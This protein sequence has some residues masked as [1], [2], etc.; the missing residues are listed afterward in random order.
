MAVRDAPAP[1]Q[2]APTASDPQAME[3]EPAQIWEPGDC[4]DP[5]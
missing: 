3:D 5:S 1:Q 2:P 4:D